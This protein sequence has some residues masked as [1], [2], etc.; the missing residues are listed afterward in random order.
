[1]K[2]KFRLNVLT[3]LPLLRRK[4]HKIIEVLSIEREIED[5]A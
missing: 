1:M 2:E 5:F 4:T 3:V